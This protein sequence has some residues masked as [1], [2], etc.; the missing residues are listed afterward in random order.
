MEEDDKQVFKQARPYIVGLVALVIELRVMDTN[1][2]VKPDWSF[3]QAENFVKEF[4]K[5]NG[6]ES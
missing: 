1:D 4:E 5:R 6:I 2:V 3:G